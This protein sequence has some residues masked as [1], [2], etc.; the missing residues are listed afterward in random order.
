MNNIQT[1]TIKSSQQSPFWDIVSYIIDVIGRLFKIIF[2]RIFRGP[3]RKSWSW[4]LEIIIRLSRASY[5]LLAK[6]GPERY[7]RVFEK[8]LPKIDGSGATI[9]LSETKEAPG[10]W[11]I[12]SKDN[13]SVILYFHGGGYVYGSAKTHGKMIGAIACAASAKTLAL[14]YRLAPKHPQP[15]AIEDACE[16][17][18]YLIKS[19]TSPKRIIFAGDSA[20][21]GLV[22]AAMLALRNAGDILPAGGV[23]ISPWVDLQ[24]SDDSFE[25]NARYDAVTKAACLVAASAYLNGSNPKEPLVSPLYA[26]LKELSPLLIHAGE[27]E[28][29]HDQ[30][31]KFA[32]RAESE[33]I[34]VT[35]KIYHDMVHVWHMFSGF[36]P[37]AE[38]AINEI[39]EFVKIVTHK[40]NN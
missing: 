9:K 22:I 29:L 30:I 21:G 2:S 40:S 18:R 5:D 24:C 32:K 7:N 25:T 26:D 6:K 15:A 4:K 11:F 17:Y 8:I 39:G 31:Y 3:L 35:F 34:D 36:T 38:K 1:R 19:G 37:E 33:G 16:A 10:H 13:G 20:G 12:P 23:C 28:V 14:D 27:L